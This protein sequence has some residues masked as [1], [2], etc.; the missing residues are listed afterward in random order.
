[1]TAEKRCAELDDGL[2]CGGNPIFSLINKQHGSFCR[3]YRIHEKMSQKQTEAVTPSSKVVG[4]PFALFPSR[5]PWTVL[6]ESKRRRGLKADVRYEALNFMHRIWAFLNY[7]HAGSPCSTSAISEAVRVAY[8]GEWTAQHETYARAM[9]SK[10]LIYCACPRGTME[11]GSAKLSALIEKIQC[12][13]YDPSISFDEANCGALPVDPTRVSLPD[14]AGILDPRKHLCGER[15]EQF[16]QMPHQI[17]EPCRSTVD[18]PACHKVSDEDWPIL[19]RKLFDADM[20]TFIPKKDVLS[21]GRRLI[22]GG[23]FC[24]PH[25]PQSDRLINDRRPA[26]L[27]EKRLN[28]CQLPSGPLLCQLILE[29]HQSVRASGD[30]LSNYFYLIKHLE[31]WHTRN[32]FG[33]PIKGSLLKGM[34]LD[35]RTLYLPAFKVVCMGDTNGVDI[36]QA[37]HEAILK[38][39]GC[40]SEVNTLIHGR[41]FPCSDTLEGLYIDDHLAMQVVPKKKCRD[42]KTY[43]DERIMKDSRQRYNDLNLPRSEKKAFDKEYIFKAWGTNVCSQSGRVGAPVEKL[44]QIESL[45]RS[46]LIG[47]YVTKKALQ[48]LIGLFVHPFMHRRECMSVFH[49]IYLY[50][51][52]LAEGKLV[53][54]PHHIR[55]EILTASLLL[56]MASSNIR[57]PVST[58]IS[59]SDASLLA[60]GRAATLT[61]KSFAKV[62]YRFGEKRGEYCKLDWVNHNLPPPTSMSAAPDCL[63]DALMCHSWTTTEKT[64]FRRKDHINLLEMQ[65]LKSEIMSRINSGRG[66]CRTVNLCDSRVVVGAYAKG[67]SSSKQL[68]HLL[69]SCLAWTIAGD[70]GV[71]NVWVDTHRNPAD[72]P[73][74]NKPIPPPDPSV[75]HPLIDPEMQH[76]VQARRSPACQEMMEQEVQRN[77]CDEKLQEPFSSGDGTTDEVQ[78][79]SCSEAQMAS[80]P[81]LTFREVFAGKARLSAAMK[82]VVG[83]KVLEPM[84]YIRKGKIDPKQDILNDE[85]FHLLKLDAQEP[86]QLWHFGLPCCSFSVL[87]HSNG[88]TR[89]RHLPQGD[90]SLERERVGNEI[91]RRTLCLIDILEANNNWWTVE[92]PDSSYAWWMPKV[93]DKLNRPQNKYVILDQCAYGLRL[94]GTNDVYGPCKK[95][96]RFAGCL[97]GL[98]NLGKR[99]KCKEPHVH[100]VGGVKTKNGWKKR[101]ELAGHYPGALAQQYANIVS[102]AL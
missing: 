32:C 10:L 50:V 37:T 58:Q 71:T 96:T 66:F 92:N 7:L 12:S 30:D 101:S 62:L 40:L 21:E 17:P 15:L 88:G 9:H 91:L 94:R 59:A 48:K 22:K 20:I 53:R 85:C 36:A 38:E 45:A 35:A 63:I 69:R 49:H 90:G 55:D 28:W 4:K 83:V 23:L 44:R 87:Q 18:P 70:L 74:R 60:G 27:R 11:R 98:I 43:D 86:N 25:K 95:S 82:K 3:Y 81:N 29:R 34:G 97:P 54:L 78:Y 31:S 84:D 5:L 24:V 8:E 73:S 46:L 6:S 42:R 2:E 65:M 33:R 52:K 79:N 80:Q 75:S 64:R 100:A 56:P 39:A 72:Y 51:E 47:G 93:R 1:M 77:S 67:R 16:E 89:R 19:L 99:C 41:V 13:Q 102:L 14:Q 57:W 26:N 61:S 76:E 68:N